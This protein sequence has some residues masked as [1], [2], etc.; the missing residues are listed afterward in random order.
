MFRQLLILTLLCF[1][2]STPTSQEETDL[3][4]SIEPIKCLLQSEIISKDI[5]ELISLLLEQDYIQ[6]VMKAIEFFPAI[7]SEVT[8]CFIETPNLSGMAENVE[9]RKCILF[10]PITFCQKY[11]D[12]TDIDVGGEQ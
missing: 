11:L 2:S 5:Q 3:S 4:F 9:Y 7:K 8:K 6:I 10:F 1:I 12:I